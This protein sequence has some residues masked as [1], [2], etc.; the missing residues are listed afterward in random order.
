MEMNDNMWWLQSDE[1]R[2]R[3]ERFA[4]ETKQEAQALSFADL[5]HAWL[6]YAPNHT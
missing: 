1:V 3:A 5:G 6:A 4:K 2:G